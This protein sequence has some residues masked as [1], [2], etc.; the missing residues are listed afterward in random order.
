MSDMS[1]HDDS[2]ILSNGTAENFWAIVFVRETPDSPHARARA[3]A[4]PRLDWVISGL[5]TPS[6]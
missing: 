6:T 2:E 5:E 1:A 3:V 4:L